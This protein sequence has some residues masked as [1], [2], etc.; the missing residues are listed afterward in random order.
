MA[1][2]TDKLT[3]DKIE[4]IIKVVQSTYTEPADFE[5]AKEVLSALGI[6]VE[7]MRI[8]A[9]RGRFDRWR[10]QCNAVVSHVER[11]HSEEWFL[12]KPT[13]EGKQKLEDWI[14]GKTIGPVQKGELVVELNGEPIPVMMR[15]HAEA[16]EFWSLD[17]IFT[18]KY[19]GAAK[20]MVIGSFHRHVS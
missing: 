2:S 20:T 16:M 9:E 14:V 1:I 18:L 13:P 19:D 7:D 12:M 5:R 10:W 15:Q 17:G 3:G 8:R 11:I 4:Q 6:Y